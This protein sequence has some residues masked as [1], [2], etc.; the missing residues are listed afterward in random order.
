MNKKIIRL[1]ESDLHSIIKEVAGTIRINERQRRLT[2]APKYATK[3]ING[4]FAFN[5][6]TTDEEIID[7]ILHDFVQKCVGLIKD[8]YAPNCAFSSTYTYSL[9]LQRYGVD[10]GYDDSTEEI[11]SD[12]PAVTCQEIYK[13]EFPKTAK[14][15]SV[16]DFRD[17]F[18]IGEFPI[19]TIWKGLHQSSKGQPE[20]VVNYSISR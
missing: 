8:T 6:E 14:L 16:E 9:F 3:I 20:I 10:D 11:F 15:F 17:M 5:K 19:I 13:K 12:I 1:T 2:E 18:G 4:L 7:T